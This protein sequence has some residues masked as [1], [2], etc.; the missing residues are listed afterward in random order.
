[1]ARGKSGGV[2]GLSKPRSGTGLGGVEMTR[3]R[4]RVALFRTRGISGGED[5]GEGDTGTFTEVEV[6]LEL[7]TGVAGS[8]LGFDWAVVGDGSGRGGGRSRS[9]GGRGEVKMFEEEI[10]EVI[11]FEE[12]IE[13]VCLLLRRGGAGTG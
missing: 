3:E 13:V 10:V 9:G 4:A 5:S 12:A 11:L 6:T 7:A 1:M 2:R 8:W